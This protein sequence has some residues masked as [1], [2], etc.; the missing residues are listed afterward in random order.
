MQIVSCGAPQG[1]SLGPVL[2]LIYINDLPNSLVA[3]MFRIFAYDTNIFASSHDAKSLGTLINAELKKA[4]DWWY[5]NKVSIN[6]STTNYMIIKSS[7]KRNHEFII[8]MQSSNGM[9]NT[10]ERKDSIKYLGVMT[11]QFLSSTGTISQRFVHER[12]KTLE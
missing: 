11:R 3:L 5:I 4:K 10:L 2:F 9:N 8:N 12:L 1:S 7:R 6:L